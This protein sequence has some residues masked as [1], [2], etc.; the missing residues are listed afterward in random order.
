MSCKN[1]ILE[2]K[3]KEKLGHLTIN[4]LLNYIA[5]PFYVELVRNVGLYK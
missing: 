5:P 4:K 3:K 2:K 1:L